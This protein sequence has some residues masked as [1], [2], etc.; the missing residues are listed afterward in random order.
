MTHLNRDLFSLFSI[1]GNGLIGKFFE[2]LKNIKIEDADKLK[3]KEYAGTS[4]YVITFNSP[5]QFEKLCEAYVNHPGFITETTNYLLDN[6]TDTSTTDEYKRIC[7]EY[8]FEHI[9]KDNLGICGGRQ[10]VAEHFNNTDAKQY[11]FLEDDMYLL[12][13]NTNKCKNGFSR[14]VPNLFS[15][16]H[17]IMDREEFDFLKFS[18]TEFY[19]DNST[20]WS[21][22]NVPQNI[23][24]KFWP[25]YN[26]LPKIGIDPKS[27]KTDFKTIK[28][29]EG[30]PY[31]TGDVYYC[32][33]P[34]IV[35]REGN[36]KMFLTT[37]W[38]HPFEQTWMSYIF[39]LTKEGTVKGAVLL[40]SPIEHDRF[41]HYKSELR[42]ES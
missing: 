39:Q 26:K 14:Y 28:I 18:F 15:K 7:K 1:D 20:Q 34:Q 6:S 19:G 24:E 31:A 37:T 41:A 3:V 13:E 9:K 27:P 35:S 17:K 40:L 11:I 25:N 8:N 4:L 30:L 5:K 32:N 22:Y 16:I 23:R 42:K 36:K 2:D 10:F 21:W 29:L 38:A 33:W 12:E